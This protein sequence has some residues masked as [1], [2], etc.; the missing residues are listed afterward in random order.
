MVKNVVTGF[1]VAALIL[2]FFLAYA[3]KHE[4]CVRGRS[5]ETFEPCG[6][7]THSI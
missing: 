6:S 4:G 3:Q 2:M 5:I 1:V 7:V